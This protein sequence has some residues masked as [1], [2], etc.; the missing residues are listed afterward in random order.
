M[1]SDHFIISCCNPSASPLLCSDFTLLRRHIGLHHFL[2]FLSQ[3]RSPCTIRS[4]GRLLYDTNLVAFLVRYP[5]RSVTIGLHSY[6][7]TLDCTTS[8]LTSPHRSPCTIRSRVSLSVQ[9]D[10]AL[11]SSRTTCSCTPFLYDTISRP[12]CVRYQS[13]SHRYY[14]TRY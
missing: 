8:F 11:F 1:Y 7:D 9:Y 2:Y 5:S 6:A 10:L 13:R 12:L 3:H 14:N 4:R